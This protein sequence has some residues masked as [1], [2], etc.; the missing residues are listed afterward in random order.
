MHS[1]RVAKEIVHIAENLLISAYEEYSYIIMLAWLDSMKRQITGLLTS[2][3]VGS[4]LSVGVASD[5]LK[6]R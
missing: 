1:I 5:V 6:L 4:D 3:H 2:I